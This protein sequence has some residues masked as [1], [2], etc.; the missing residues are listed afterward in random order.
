MIKNNILKW[1]K[2][3]ITSTCNSLGTLLKSNI[4]STE[5]YTTEVIIPIALTSGFLNQIRLSYYSMDLAGFLDGALR[6]NVI[7]SGC[8]RKDLFTVERHSPEISETAQI[9]FNKF[10]QWVKNKKHIRL[11]KVPEDFIKSQYPTPFAHCNFRFHIPLSTSCKAIILCDA[12]TVFLQNFDPVSLIGEHD[13]PAVAGHM[14]HY[15]PAYTEDGIVTTVTEQRWA[16]IFDKLE[17]PHNTIKHNC[18]IGGNEHGFQPPNFNFGFVVVNPQMYY[19]LSMNFNRYRKTVTET[20]KTPMSGQISVMAIGLENKAK[21]NLLPANYNAANDSLHWEKNKLRKEDI[22]VLH[23][24]REH[25]FVREKFLNVQHLEGFLAG[26][27]NV[28]GTQLLR[29]RVKEVRARFG[30]TIFES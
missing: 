4:D 6:I 18:S 20:L 2:N 25:E 7:Y 12:D 8:E 11:I 13:G 10:Q 29:D 14:V 17:L 5:K 19:L 3:K 24:L 30:D 23:Y 15:P 16:D 22:F 9:N 27:S 21:F 26:E 1:L 28:E